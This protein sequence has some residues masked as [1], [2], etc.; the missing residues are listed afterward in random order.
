MRQ[1]GDR[2]AAPAGPPLELM[3]RG[4]GH[5]SHDVMTCSACGKPI[6]PKDVQALPG[7]G[8]AEPLADRRLADAVLDQGL[9]NALALL[10]AG[11]QR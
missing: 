11:Q 1:W 7:P 10:S 2:H 3:H 5:I 9:Q 4:C 8:A 6:G